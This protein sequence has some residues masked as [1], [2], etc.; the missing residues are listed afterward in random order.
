MS[1]LGVVEKV[2]VAVEISLVVVI[3]ADIA[4]IYADFKAFPVFRPPY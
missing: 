3:Q 4:W 1:E 2:G